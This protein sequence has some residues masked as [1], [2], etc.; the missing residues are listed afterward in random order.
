M[1]RYKEV[2]ALAAG[3]ISDCVSSLKNMIAGYLSLF[4]PTFL[5]FTKDPNP[6]IRNN[7]I[8]GIGEMALYGKEKAYPYPFQLILRPERTGNNDR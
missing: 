7:V 4:I 2:R 5:R 8:Y 6:E 3:M 1:N